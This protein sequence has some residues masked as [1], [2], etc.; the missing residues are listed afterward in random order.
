LLSVERLIPFLLNT[1]QLLQ[2]PKK[3]ISFVIVS[4]N[5]NLQPRFKLKNT[6]IISRLQ[7]FM[8]LVIFTFSIMSK[9]VVH[10]LIADHVDYKIA[11]SHDETSVSQ[12][13]FNC[14]CNDLVVSSPYITTVTT[15]R[16]SANLLY[17]TYQTP[18]LDFIQLNPHTTKDL[19]GPPA[20]A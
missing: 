18:A 4:N 17:Q 10:D 5:H 1:S 20:S 15:C 13:G 3:K 19:R 14:D 9:Q 6:A 2:T 12:A 7:A 11:F 8:M 16:L